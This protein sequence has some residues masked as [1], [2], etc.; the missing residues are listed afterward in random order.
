MSRSPAGHEYHV[1]AYRCMFTGLLSSVRLRSECAIPSP[2]EGEV[3]PGF[4]LEKTTSA[5]RDFVC[6]DC[7]RSLLTR[8]IFL[9]RMLLRQPRQRTLRCPQDALAT[10]F[11]TCNNSQNIMASANSTLAAC[12]TPQRVVIHPC[13]ARRAFTCHANSQMHGAGYE[14]LPLAA[15][16]AI[17]QSA[18]PETRAWA[19]ARTQDMQHTAVTRMGMLERPHAASRTTSEATQCL[20]FTGPPRARPAQRTRK[21]G[22]PSC[23]FE[24]LMVRG[25]ELIRARSSFLHMHKQCYMHGCPGP[26]SEDPGPP[27]LGIAS[28]HKS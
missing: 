4:S 6:T 20:P 19:A 22:E 9:R 17:R 2:P 8:V 18:G 1:L 13:N 7:T 11:S 24:Q 16:S 15:R 23:G 10:A 12:S 27:C 14:Q 25:W 5:R 21:R 28:R 26:L 3:A